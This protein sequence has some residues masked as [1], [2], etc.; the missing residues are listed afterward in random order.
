MNERERVLA[1][2]HRQKPDRV[3]W[4]AKLELW[5]NARIATGTLPERFKGRSLWDID[6]ELGIGIRAWTD[7]VTLQNDG[8]EKIVG[9]EG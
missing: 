3:P 2:L 9:R 1:V 6:R 8:F 5:Y 7:L 4:V